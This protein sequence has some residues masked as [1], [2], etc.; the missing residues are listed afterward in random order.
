MEQKYRQKD[1]LK[2]SYRALTRTALDIYE[3][4]N[5]NDNK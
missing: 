4:M 5:I 2:K 3:E 1:R